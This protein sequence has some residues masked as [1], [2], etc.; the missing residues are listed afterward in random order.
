MN[1][2]V[3][4]FA[5]NTQNESTRSIS[6]ELENTEDD[7]IRR[8]QPSEKCSLHVLSSQ[9]EPGCR[10]MYDRIEDRVIISKIELHNQYVSSS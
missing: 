2:F 8:V 1:K 9:P 3:S 4:Q 5:F 6:Q 10:F 7:V